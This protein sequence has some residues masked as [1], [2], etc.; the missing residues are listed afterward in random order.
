M[1]QLQK[2]RL[3]E[4]LS[5]NAGNYR[6]FYMALIKWLSVF[7]SGFSSVKQEYCLFFK[8]SNCF[9]GLNS[10]LLQLCNPTEVIG[11]WFTICK[12]FRNKNMFIIGVHMKAV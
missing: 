4:F 5:S 2:S 6:G 8:R 3:L 12:C 11:H 7:A 10:L 9:N 1:L